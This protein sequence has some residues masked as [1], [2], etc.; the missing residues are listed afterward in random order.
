M[1]IKDSFIFSEVIVN[2]LKLSGEAATVYQNI[3]VKF[4]SRSQRSVKGDVMIVKECS[5]TRNLHTKDVESRSGHKGDKH[6]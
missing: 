6:T 4:V 1:P 2:S 3:A 5:L